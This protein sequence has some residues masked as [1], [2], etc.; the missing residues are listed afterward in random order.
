MGWKQA[1]KWDVAP[2][3]LS[4]PRKADMENL[5]TKGGVGNISATDS[6]EDVA[7]L[8]DLQRKKNMD[9]LFLLAKK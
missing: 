4:Y 2:K 9:K 8:K 3:S 5:L 1:L 7:S 6:G